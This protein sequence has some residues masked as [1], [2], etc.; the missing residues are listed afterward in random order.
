[1]VRGSAILLLVSSASVLLFPCAGPAA[2]SSADVQAS[3]VAAADPDGEGVCGECPWSL[4]ET[5]PRHPAVPSPALPAG[6]LAPVRPAP[7]D[8][9]GHGRGPTLASLAVSMILSRPPPLVVADREIAG[10]VDAN[11]RTW[12]R[13]ELR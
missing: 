6:G 7:D 10:Y 1:M 3:V 4:P 5:D 13:R 2:G 12:T 11:R 9:R 8:I